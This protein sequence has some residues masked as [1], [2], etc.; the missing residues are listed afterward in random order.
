MTSPTV[1]VVTPTFNRAAVLPRLWRSLCRQPVP[2]EWIV[3]DDASTDSTPSVVQSIGDPRIVVAGLDRNRGQNA[4]RNAGVCL[5]RGAF[6]VF[7]DSDD[8]FAPGA[9]QEAVQAI[10][11]APAVVGAVLM[12]AQPTFSTHSVEVR[13]HRGPPL[14]APQRCREFFSDDLRRTR[15]AARAACRQNRDGPPTTRCHIEL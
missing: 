13:E 4:A 8:E 5:S 2:F 11:N 12:I 9:L 6:I 10:Q 15:A 3:V 1:S 14:P 7:V